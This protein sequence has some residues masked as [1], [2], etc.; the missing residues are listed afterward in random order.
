[1]IEYTLEWYLKQAK[2]VLLKWGEPWMIRDQDN[3]GLVSYYMMIA[4][5]TYDPQRGSKQSSWRV[6]R[7]RYAVKTIKSN[8]ARK[9]KKQ[10]VLSLNSKTSPDGGK[11]LEWGDMV[12]DRDRTP[13]VDVDFVISKSKLTNKQAF[14]VSELRSGKKM[15]EIAKSCGV[16]KQAVS[17]SVA[18]AV[19]KMKRNVDE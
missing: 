5:Q 17:Y 3:I 16:C 11:E 19:E 9:L 18:K 15:T 10:I 7:G 2:A 1:M 12:A 6:L 14:Y 8:R 4:D 13:D